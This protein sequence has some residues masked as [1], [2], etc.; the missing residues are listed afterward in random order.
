M[1]LIALLVSYLVG[2]IPFAYIV[3][4]LAKG[5]DIRKLGSG[6]VGATNVARLLGKKWGVI[7]FILD[8]LKGFI[9]PFIVSIFVKDPPNIL[10]IAAGIAAVCGHNWTPFLFFKGGKGVSTSLGVI[11]GFCFKFTFLVYP[12]IIALVCWVMVFLISKIV[13]LASIISSLSFAIFSFVFPIPVEFRIFSLLLFI[14]ILIRHK[15]NIMNL[16]QKKE[17]HF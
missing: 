3:G 11:G 8:F 2:S 5:I 12:F 7:V 9:A 16:L 13:S 6:N 4:R 17:L 14:F 1:F 10:L 15:K